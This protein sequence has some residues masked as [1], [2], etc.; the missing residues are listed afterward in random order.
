MT[1]T[2]YNYDDYVKSLEKILAMLEKD[3]WVQYIDVNRH[4]VNV[5][6]TYLWVAA[7]LIGAYTA[8]YSQYEI[9]FLSSGFCTF[10]I[11]AISILLAVIAFGTCLWAIPARK[12]YKP[13]PEISW[14]E[15]SKMA[16]NQLCEKENSYISVL[17]NLVDR[18]DSS[19]FYN[20]RTNI[21]RATLLR[22]TSWILIASFSMFFL[23]GVTF[24]FSQLEFTTSLKSKQEVIMGKDDN[25]S[26]KPDTSPQEQPADNKPNVPEP[27]GPIGTSP[28][29]YT[30][31]AEQPDKG[32]IQVTEG[33][34]VG[35]GHREIIIERTKKE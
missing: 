33:E 4:Q 14:G 16:Y 27:A 11:Y 26:Q 32:N 34:K 22:I 13:I 29:N 6:K 35:G 19:N 31:H 25:T 21:K 30:T 3:Y 12:G 9:I 15:F 2:E 20:I 8:L 1:E 24:S 28:P 18:V 5:A 10:S 23:S 7:A 17:T